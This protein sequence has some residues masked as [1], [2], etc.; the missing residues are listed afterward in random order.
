MEPGWISQTA[1]DAKLARQGGN[2]THRQLERWRDEGLLPAVRQIANYKGSSIEYPADYARQVVAIERALAV[3]NRIDFA[4]A[5]LWFAGFEVDERF[6][7]GSIQTADRFWRRALKLGRVALRHDGSSTIG[8]QISTLDRMQGV[9]ANIRRR[10]DD[11]QFARL[12]NV[13]A[14]IAGGE[15][16]GFDFPA[17][18]D[19][20]SSEGAFHQAFDFEKSKNQNINGAGIKFHSALNGVL[21]DISKSLNSKYDHKILDLE[22]EISKRSIIGGMKIGICLNEAFSWFYGDRA[23]GLRLSGLIA[24]IAPIGSI[25]N[26]ILAF[27]RMRRISNDFY[28]VE[29]IEQM[30]RQSE[31]IWL[32]SIYFRELQ[33]NDPALRKFIGPKRLKSAFTDSREMANL[34]SE[35]R[36]LDLP[37]PDFRPWDQWRKLAKKTMSPG[38]LAMSIGAPLIMAAED[39]DL[40]G[41]AVASR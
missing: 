29:E 33:E 8:D 12:I 30:A 22:I 27:A 35:L 21:R 17:D 1:F 38:L 37:K 34:L 3:K 23:L 9:L 36:G 16:E 28:S 25:S 18:A 14:E 31:A 5:V 32:A 15:F 10:V 39:I 19:E 24:R 6:W 11:D 41:N 40:F 20:F 26:F 4:G 13:G 2:A 7:R